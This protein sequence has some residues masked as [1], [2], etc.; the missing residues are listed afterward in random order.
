MSQSA[1]TTGNLPNSSERHFVDLADLHAARLDYR[2]ILG[3]VGFFFWMHPSAPYLE[4]LAAC[5]AHYHKPRRFKDEDYPVFL[6][7]I[8]ETGK[9]PLWVGRWLCH[10]V[11]RPEKPEVL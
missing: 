1:R 3:L 8:Q 11:T 6:K 5:D 2:N 9:V 4:V 7:Q 10:G